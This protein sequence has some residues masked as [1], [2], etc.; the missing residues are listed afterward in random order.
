LQAGRLIEKKGFQTTLRAFAAFQRRIPGAILT[1][2]GEGPM[3]D[4][5]QNLARELNVA[6]HVFFV[7]FLSQAELREQFYRAH[8]F[9]H[10]SELGADGNQEG[11]P[12]AML[13]AM[14]SGVPGVSTDV[15]SSRN[16]RV[17][18]E[19]RLGGGGRS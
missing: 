2:A 16:N 6:D 3:L 15:G 18:S 8:I 19:R 13:E 4:D 11:V 10:P 14:A 1:I 12:N 17:G 9:L 7:G 5:L